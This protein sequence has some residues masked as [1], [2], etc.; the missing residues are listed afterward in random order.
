MIY[1]KL[2]ILPTGW[3]PPGYKYLGPGNS[4][5]KG[6]PTNASDAAAKLHDQAYDEYIK[7]GH[8]PYWN[9][10]KAD[11]AFIKATNNASDWGGKLGNLIFRAKRHIFPHLKELNL[12]GGQTR[13][14]PPAHIFVNI[15]RK[16]A[17]GLP[18]R[19]ERQP[20]PQ[21]NNQPE[22]Q[23]QNDQP[24]GMAAAAGDNQQPASGGS[25]RSGGV[26]V[27][28]GDFD[29][30]TLWTFHGDGTVT[31]TCNSSRLVHLNMPD[32]IDY[33]I[34]PVSNDTAN[35]TR[36]RMMDD[37]NHTQVVTPW[38][39]IDCNAWGVWLTPRDWQQLTNFCEEIELVS[40][41]QSIFNVTIKTATETGP[42]DARI[43]VYNNDLT[44]VLMCA[45]D[46]NNAL[47]FTPAAP[48]CETLGFWAW[49][50]TTI[51][52]WRYYFDSD[53][54]LTPTTSNNTNQ[55]I[56]NF[57]RIDWAD[58]QFFTVETTCPINLLRTGDEISTG[59]YHFDCNRLHL[60]RHWQT[61]RA[62][63]LPPKIQVPSS[64]SQNGTITEADRRG[65]RWGTNTQHETN[66]IRPATTGYNH[67][68]WFYTNGVEGP[69]I[70]PAPP[71]Y[72]PGGW[73][74]GIPP[75]QPQAQNNLQRVTYDYNHGN[76]DTNNENYSYQV[77]GEVGS[78]IPQGNFLTYDNVPN[79][80]VT[81]GEN[82]TGTG[83]TGYT[84]RDLIRNMPNTY[85][86]YTASDHQ[87]PL[88]PHGQIWDKQLDTDIKPD[89]H[90]LAPFVCRNNPPGQILV[91]LAPNLTDRFSPG[92]TFAEIITYT[93]FWWKGTLTIKAKLRAPH[94]FNMTT[95]I[96]PTT[97][98][99]A[100][101]FLPN[102]VGH[103]E[104]P[105]LSA[106]YVPKPIY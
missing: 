1:L 92:P 6:D 4:L 33:K 91:K 45:M 16:K 2:S 48:R 90:C 73:S 98:G 40:L 39:L 105:N 94:Q 51:P 97:P 77:W 10:N 64:T 83:E 80:A 63:G 74:N 65:W 59:I 43:T 22:N 5:D 20:A 60:N 84:D 3:V 38:S 18:T 25:S 11:D 67:P 55:Q 72:F 41:E 66:V 15:A 12:A 44:A 81:S 57:N 89:L 70:D 14:R 50:P 49:R 61:N 8:N 100:D 93:D 47:P 106:R 79:Q 86:V 75:D 62:L 27:S 36:G 69:Y 85:G 7:Q 21:N 104:L 32:S 58:G 42:T 30:T 88:Y 26:G 28:T 24:D 52:R 71:T 53:R 29:N 35:T 9:F 68:E 46:T 37:D 101:R 99:S 56:E 82:G 34:V 96:T 19:R 87:G 103:L 78:I 23:I 76:D 102:R 17:K 13:K 54:W 31:I 95:M